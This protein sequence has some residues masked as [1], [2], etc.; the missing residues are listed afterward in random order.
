M[1]LNGYFKYKK[2]FFRKLFKLIFLEDILEY[3]LKDIFRRIY[4]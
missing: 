2:L 4:F 1:K 3:I